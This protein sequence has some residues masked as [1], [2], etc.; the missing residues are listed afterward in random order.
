MQEYGTVSGRPR[1]T[2]LDLHFD[3]LKNAAMINGATQIA[4]TKIDVRF[5]GNAGVKDYSR[6][7]KEAKS[8][9]DNVE[10]KIGVPVT[11]IGTGP[12]AEDIV[13]RRKK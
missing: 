5:P 10:K 7:T 4:L 2:S 9:I 3:D 13:D 8:F 6:L 1:R 11:I 12:D